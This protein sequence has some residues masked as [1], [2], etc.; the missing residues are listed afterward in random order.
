MAFHC[1]SLGSPRAENM[2]NA[3]FEMET[4]LDSDWHN[5]DKCGSLTKK[6]VLRWY[7]DS[8]LI[9]NSDCN[10]RSDF[11]VFGPVKNCKFYLV[12]CSNPNATYFTVGLCR[13]FQGGPFSRQQHDNDLDIKVAFSLLDMR[14]RCHHTCERTLKHAHFSVQASF[15]RTC[16]ST[17]HLMFLRSGCLVLHCALDVNELL[18]EDS[19]TSNNQTRSSIHSGD[20]MT[21]D[22][23]ADFRSLLDTGLHSDVV[24]KI[25][26]QDIKAHRAILAA[27]S[28]VFKAMFEHDTLEKNNNE[29]VIT[30]LTEESMTELL[31]FL[32]TGEVGDLNAQELLSLLVAADKY[33][34]PKLKEQCS[35]SLCPLIT[36]EIALN[37]M[38]LSN[39]HGDEELK[40][41]AV[42]VVLDNAMEVMRSPEWLTF[43]KE[44]PEIANDIILN[45]AM[46]SLKMP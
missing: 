31:K 10:I 27:R 8:N 17:Q 32:Y 42:Q 16:Y 44:Y 20:E 21:R 38:V 6:D 18:K 28:P 46:K 43:L 12:V 11:F 35:N 4:P 7:I 15:D 25:G 22:W 9:K 40:S 13:V 19:A 37:V 24:L 14:D 26:D 41:A 2:T 45:L 39:L 36:N 33:N 29:V 30:D 34:L 23:T 3:L 1:P 5:L